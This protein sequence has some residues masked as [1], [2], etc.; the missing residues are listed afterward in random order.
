MFVFGTKAPE[1]FVDRL[2]KWPSYCNHILQ[3]SHLRSSHFE[4]VAFIERAHERISSGH[5]ESDGHNASMD[6]QHG[7]IQAN[8]PNMERHLLVQLIAIIVQLSVQS[9]VGISRN[10][11]QSHFDYTK[12]RNELFDMFD[13]LHHESGKLSS[14]SM[15]DGMLGDNMLFEYEADLATSKQLIDIL[16]KYIHFD[17]ASGIFGHPQLSKNKSVVLWLSAALLLCSG[18]ESCFHF[19]NSGGME[20]LTYIFI[21]HDM[22]NSHAITLMKQPHDVASLA[23]HILHRLRFYELLPDTSLQYY[24]LAS[25]STSRRVTNATVDKL[26]SARFQLK[27]LMKMINSCAPL[28][29]P[30]PLACTSRSLLLGETEGVLSYKS[31]CSL[32]TSSNCWFSNWDIDSHLLVLLKCSNRVIEGEGILSFVSCTIIIYLTVSNGNA[33]DIFVDIASCLG[34]VILSL[35]F[36]RSGLIF[37]HHLEL[38]TNVI[39]ALRGSVGLKKEEPLPLRYA[40]F[41]ISKGFLCQPE[42]IGMI[43]EKHLR[44]VEIL[45]HCIECN[46][47]GLGFILTDADEMNYRS[48]CGRQALLA[49]GHF[50]EA[51]SVLIAA[52]QSIKELDPD[53]SNSGSP[54]NF[55]FK[56]WSN[57]KDA[58]TRLL[59]WVDAS[60]VYHSK[61]ATGLIR[62]LIEKPI[63][64]NSYRAAVLRDSSVAPMTTAFRIL[65]FISENSAVATALY[66]EGVVMVI[67]A[68]LIDFRLMLKSGHWTLDD[69]YSRPACWCSG[70]WGLVPD[71]PATLLGNEWER[72]KILSVIQGLYILI[73]TSRVSSKKDEINCATAMVPYG[74]IQ[75]ILNRIGRLRF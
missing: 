73:L 56:F 67:H 26:T 62:N 75:A 71:S 57:R 5:S 54:L 4:R 25:L 40:S 8:A 64:E 32:I 45:I 48:H 16:Q 34:A 12:A 9:L 66:D 33:V 20:Q 61:E 14:E 28:E 11:G 17:R 50:P 74:R 18:H 24:L 59:E 72:A 51:V 7:S 55:I 6:L 10:Y 53:T 68:V 38:S 3:M 60:I 13:S 52:L 70:C 15:G 21:I 69:T 1:Q 22:Q 29:D 31:T 36:C 41:L 49:L 42:E 23:T 43:V 44:V 30:S 47:N 35:L 63:S 65:A 46:I 58:P 19:V 27:T 2:I 37:L 39:L